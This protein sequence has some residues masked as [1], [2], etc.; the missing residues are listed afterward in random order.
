MKSEG[1]SLIRSSV[2]RDD[3]FSLL[4][5]R[6]GRSAKIKVTAVA[7]Q[8]YSYANSSIDISSS[9]AQFQRLEHKDLL[10]NLSGEVKLFKGKD[11]VYLL[12]NPRLARRIYPVSARLVCDKDVLRLITGGDAIYYWK[13]VV[14]GRIYHLPK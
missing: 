3:T 11:E 6:P 9:N 12:P 10:T 13:V 8:N 4:K 14:E 5:L 1:L 2:S 7:F